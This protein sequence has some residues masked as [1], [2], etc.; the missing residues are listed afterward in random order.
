MSARPR[1]ATSSRR[2]ASRSASAASSRSTTSTS[3]CRTSRIVAIIGPNGAGKTTFFNCMTGLYKPTTGHGPVRRRGHHRQGAA[4]RHPG[5]RRAHVPEHQAVQ[6]DDRARERAGRAPRAHEGAHHR[7]DPPHAVRAARGARD[8][9]V[10]GRPAQVRRHL[11]PPADDLAAQPALRRPAPARDRA[12]ARLGSEAAAARRADGGHEPAG[13]RAAARAD[14]DPA[15]ERGI[16]DAADRARH[17]GRHERLRPHHGARRRRE[18]RRRARPQEVRANPRVIEA[19]LGS[20][21]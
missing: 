13:V 11:G 6:D 12:R 5:R 1:T 20:Q 17:E 18:D 7:L 14:G 9:G 10:R 15:H 21:A 8:R 3:S 16:I 19:Y 4:H 2:P